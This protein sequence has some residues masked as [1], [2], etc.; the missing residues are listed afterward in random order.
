MGNLSFAV[1]TSEFNRAFVQYQI[2]NASRV[3]FYIYIRHNI[4]ALIDKE[5]TILRKDFEYL[6]HRFVGR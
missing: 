2:R 1:F 6:H 3:F 5:L 4:I